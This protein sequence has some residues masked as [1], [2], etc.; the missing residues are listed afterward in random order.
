MDDLI[1]KKKINCFGIEIHNFDI[2]NEYHTS[3]L[4]ELLDEYLVVVL[5][6]CPLTPHEQTELA[7]IFGEV[8]AA[9]PVIQ[10]NED[11]PELFEFDGSKGGKNA[12]WHT[13]VSFLENP[14]SVSVLVPVKLPEEAGGDTLFADLRTSYQKINDNMKDFLE[15]LEAVHKVTPLA[16]WGE[17][18]D[19]LSSTNK[20]ISF[21]YKE[22][23]KINP[24]IH[25]VVRVHPRTQKPAFFVN[26]GFTSHILNISNI[27]N[28]NILTMIYEHTT[29]PEFILRHKWENNDVVIWD[30]ICTAHYAVNDY[31]LFPRKMRRVT[32]KG[33]IPV[34]YNHLRSRKITD[35]LQTVR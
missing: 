18:F 31:G 24:V 28:N 21:L 27:E 2:K 32:V 34:G 4:Q 17:P 29:Q 13:D 20:E 3:I 30:N 14:H 25:P 10:G 12:K 22:S 23:K 6:D 1:Y 15:S 26:P 11:Q 16:Y 8:T 35:I 19:Y 33:D 5:R 7:S 9:H